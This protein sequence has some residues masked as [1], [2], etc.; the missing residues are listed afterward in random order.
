MAATPVSLQHHFADLIDPRSERSCQHELLDIVGIALCAV[1]SGAEAWT[2]IE[3][4]GHAKRDWLA[5]FF[6]L[7]N[8]IPSHDTFRRVFC[9]LDPEAFQRS[10]ADWIAALAACGVGDRRLV[11]I[12]GKTVRRSGRRGLGLTPLH[13]VSAWAGANHVSLGQV[14]VDDKSNEITA[15]PRLL[16]LLDLS[17]AW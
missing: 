6:R 8:G 11:P 14:A 12:D 7:P 16:E 9:L 17:G 15:I 10:F 4:Y 2:A 1:I 5:Q 13:L 3:A